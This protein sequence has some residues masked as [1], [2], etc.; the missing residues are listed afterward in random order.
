MQSGGRESGWAV[1][2]ITLRS[3]GIGRPAVSVGSASSAGRAVKRKQTTELSVC[4]QSE[5]HISHPPRQSAAAR[6]QHASD[7][8]GTARGSGH[9]ELASHMQLFVCCS[10]MF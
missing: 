5:S 1:A 4:V 2:V 7:Q 10:N 9:D 6:P 8:D 3:I